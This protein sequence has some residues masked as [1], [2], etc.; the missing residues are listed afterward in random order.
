MLDLV[1]TSQRFSIFNCSVDYHSKAAKLVGKGQEIFVATILA[2]Y[3]GKA[4][5][6][7]TAMRGKLYI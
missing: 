1:S 3:T 4:V 5:M 6:K 7:I 2:L